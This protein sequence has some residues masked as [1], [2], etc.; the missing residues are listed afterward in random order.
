MC[1]QSLKNF[2]NKCFVVAMENQIATNSLFTNFI[3]YNYFNFFFLMFLYYI[4]PF[5]FYFS[6]YYVIKKLNF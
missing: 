1:Y 2:L 3:L 6:I 5:Y 4:P